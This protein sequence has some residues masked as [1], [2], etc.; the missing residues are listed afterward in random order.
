MSSEDFPAA[1]W[2]DIT[3]T[4]KACRTRRAR[5]I[6]IF[7]C[8]DRRG[9]HGR[10]SGSSSRGS[11]STSSTG[12]PSYHLLTISV[13]RQVSCVGLAFCS[14]VSL[15]SITSTTSGELWAYLHTS[16]PIVL[17]TRIAG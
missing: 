16:C 9:Y 13:P 5:G 17:Y 3:A 2:Q 10:N 15:S 1:A 7:L 14:K 4:Q 11:D 6:L 12:S 8:A